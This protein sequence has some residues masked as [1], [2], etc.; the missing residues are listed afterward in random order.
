MPRAS[1][2]V[3]DGHL[4]P[5]HL[6]HRQHWQKKKEKRADL[7]APYVMSDIKE[8]QSPIDGQQITTRSQLRQHLKDHGCIEIGNERIKSPQRDEKAERE[9]IAKDIKDAI[10]M[11]R[12]GHIPPERPDRRDGYDGPVDPIKAE[13]IDASSLSDGAYV[14]TNAEGV[15][16]ER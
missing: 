8:F 16:N 15:V 11:V 13:K 4:I 14:R 12:A 7:P 10:E 9:E 1:Y 5:K 2:V 6:A 3:R